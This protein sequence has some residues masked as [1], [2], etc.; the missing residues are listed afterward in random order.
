MLDIHTV[1]IVPITL[2]STSSIPYI[3]MIETDYA[4][5]IFSFKSIWF[6]KRS[7]LIFGRKEKKI[8]HIAIIR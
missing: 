3:T 7:L 1:Y 2:H 6:G 8:L 5:G 4:R